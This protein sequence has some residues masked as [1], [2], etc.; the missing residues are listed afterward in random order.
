VLVASSVSGSLKVQEG[1]EGGI[2]AATKGK[3]RP[4][5]G[6]KK[7]RRQRKKNYKKKG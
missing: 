4:L 7:L 6:E 3:S 5:I 2:A 1:E